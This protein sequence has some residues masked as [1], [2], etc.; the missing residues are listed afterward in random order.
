MVI[1]LLPLV[2]VGVL[3]LLLSKLR[4]EGGPDVG[5]ST[6]AGPVDLPAR[7]PSATLERGG[8]AAIAR[9]LGRV[10]SRQLVGS[11][12]FAMGIAF[13]AMIVA[14]FGI[15]WSGDF[16]ERWENIWIF[17]PIFAY[18]MV[19]LTVIGVHAAVTRER[20]DGAAELFSSCPVSP[21]VRTAAHLRT[22]WVPVVSI[23]AF[24]G[25]FGLASVWR[26]SAFGSIPLRTAGDV[27]A[28]V[29]LGIGGTCLGVAI[30]RWAPWWPAPIVAIVFVAVASGAISGIGEPG[31]WSQTRQ[32]STFPRYPD[33]DPVFAVRPVWWHLAWLLALSAAVAMIA[34][35][36]DRRDRPVFATGAVVVV[37]LLVTGYATSRPLDAR[38]A[39]RVASMVAY[40]A[41]HQQC[42]E[43]LG[44]DFCTYA[45]FEELATMVAE[46]LVPVL[47]GLPDAAPQQLV[48]RQGYEDRLSE[49]DPEVLER[50]PRPLPDV[51]AD[52]H[53]TFSS[54]PEVLVGARIATGLWAVGLPAQA[55]PGTSTQVIAGEARGV[56]A[57]WIAA[58]GL[59][60]D[61]AADLASAHPDPNSDT[62]DTPFAQGMAWPEPCE[63]GPSPVVWAAQDLVAARALLAVPEDEVQ[64]QLDAD[65]E[66]FTDP[67]TTTA[68]LLERF[69]LPDV[70]PIDEVRP[71]VWECSY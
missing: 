44:G 41:R 18:P 16:E 50:L 3:L 15:I 28:A 14:L 35:A 31:H 8:A 12:S 42:L 6:S 53:L 5:W 7:T 65:W 45:G 71:G 60:P 57:L 25:V 66:L 49:L 34:V 56:V 46:E 4:R 30:A 33:Y 37:A 10:E 17:A 54:H 24:L 64:Q 48:V 40:P 69:G 2:L 11:F 55:G 52:L 51:D 70:G 59:G 36:R 27:L 29:A 38:E 63:V 68:Q 39:E 43:R 20:R 21:A 1:I 58:R 26:G 67:G 19:G 61:E 23:L 47:R 13:S 22:A 62:R 9:A 32:L